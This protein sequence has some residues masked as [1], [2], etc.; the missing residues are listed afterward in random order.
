M[1]TS[2][3]PRRPVTVTFVAVLAV[4]LGLLS[5]I[6]GIL[7]IALRDDLERQA[8]ADATSSQL[9]IAGVVAVIFGLIY[10]MVARG[11]LSGNSFS[12]FIV[13]LVSIVLVAGGVYTVIVYGGHL[14]L[15]GVADIVWGIL[16]IFL[17]STARAKDFFS[18]R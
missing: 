14:R 15:Q 9:V 16:L 17:L 18:G 8:S 5:I 12:R 1:S 4:I 3:T 6:F 2:L 10:L 13:L 11:L 7:T